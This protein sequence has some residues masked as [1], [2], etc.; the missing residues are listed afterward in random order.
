VTPK[1]HWQDRVVERSL[2]RAAASAG[3]RRT[4]EAVARRALK[5]ATKMVAAATTLLEERQSSA[6][7]L[8]EVLDRADTSLQTFY[9]HFSAKDELM[10]AVLEELVTRSTDQLRRLS[11][12]E[13]DPV[14]QLQRVVKGPFKSR[15]A[16]LNGR[17][18]VGEHLRLVEVYP[19][20]VRL[21]DLPF[22]DLLT[23]T[24]Q[25]CQAIGRF[26]GVRA[27]DEAELINDLVRVRFHSLTLGLVRRSPSAEAE[28]VWRFCLPAL[29]RNESPTVERGL[30]VRGV[31][32]NGKPSATPHVAAGL[33]AR[34]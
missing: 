33:S 18:V 32:A 34:T 15:T 14:R 20:E 17:A 2:E 4:P 5:P 9:R 29:S 3:D 31:R 27:E 11:L 16:S 13:R 23:E 24:I 28:Q 21:A 30:R 25:R 1:R 10:L 19:E 8:Q 7:T 6:F 12:R 22:S 26:P